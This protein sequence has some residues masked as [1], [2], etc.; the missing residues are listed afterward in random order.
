MNKKF[1]IILILIVVVGI[2]A[3]SCIKKS[4]NPTIKVRIALPPYTGDLPFYVAIEKGYFADQKL[5]IEIIQTKESSEALNASLAGKVDI[6][7][8]ISFSALLAAEIKSP[9]EFKLFLPGGESDKIIGSY[10]LIKK[11]ST[12]KEIKELKGKKIGTYTGATQ[13]LY[14]KLFLIEVG[15]DPDKDITIIQVAP[16]LQAQALEANQ[17]DALFTIEPYSTIAIQNGI[18]RVLIEN[19]R[20]KYIVNPFISG[21]AAVSTKF[22]KEN[23]NIL[24]NIYKALSQG[25]DFIRTNETGA[26]EILPKYTPL[27][28]SLAQK[29]GLIEWYKVDEPVNY[30]AIQKISDL[31]YENKILSSRVEVK[32]MFLEKNQLE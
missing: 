25:L 20:V 17:Y 16:E 19:P 31:L 26:R 4:E 18:A 29:A 13:L 9:G 12:I 1:L 32:S 24:K 5:N 22:V 8:P 21:S 14:L 10:L 28:A 11:D 30:G 7:A 6:I 27:D 23:P 3:V 15:F 2:I